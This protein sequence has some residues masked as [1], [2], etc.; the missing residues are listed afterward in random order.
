MEQHSYRYLQSLVD[1][2]FQIVDGEP[3]IIDWDVKNE[4]GT[5]VGKIKD[6]LFDAQTRA[7]RYLIIDLNDNGMGMD[8]K[9]VMIPIGIAHLHTSY[10]EVVLPNIHIDQYRALPAYEAEKIGPDTEVRTRQV[11]GSP[12]A[13][14]IE[15]ETAQFD[16]DQFYSHHHFNKQDFFRRGGN[17]NKFK[18]TV[19]DH[20]IVDPNHRSDITALDNFDTAVGITTKDEDKPWLKEGAGH[21]YGADN[22]NVG[23]IRLDKDKPLY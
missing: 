12:A 3:N 14:R 2:D 4:N 10:D 16:Q 11:I 6:L 13:L 1:S 22:D 23:G 20:K 15:E 7:V 17:P 5:F 8:D 9:K 21:K 18:T 19:N